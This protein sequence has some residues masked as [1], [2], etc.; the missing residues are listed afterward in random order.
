[1]GAGFPIRDAAVV[2]I[3]VEKDGSVTVLSGIAE[4]GQGG[5]N[6]VLQL[7]SEVLGLSMDSLRLSPLDTAYVPDSGAT[8]GSRGT[9]TSGNAAY[10]AAMNLKT[11]MSRIIARH[12]DV[13]QSKIT[14]A[15]NMLFVSGQDL[16]MRF[17]E[18]VSC[19]LKELPCLQGSGSWALPPVWWNFEKQC[20]ETYASFNFGA[21]GV[22]IEIDLISGAVELLN[23][24]SV[25]DIGRA[26]NVREIQGQIAGGAS[27]GYG[28]ALLEED[29]S[30]GEKNLT[31]NFDKYLLPTML[32]FPELEAIPLEAAPGCNPLGVKGVGEPASA[33]IAPAIINAI[34]DALQVRIRKLP[35][36]L[37]SVFAAI[38]ERDRIR[39]AVK[40]EAHA[41]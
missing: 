33:I 40:G 24:V 38:E 23:C 29:L 8:V 35:A 19:C 5:G 11:R 36:S 3:N 1:M 26:L 10:A 17:T 21:C 30:S 12:W 14:F 6:V 2:N 25:H 13:P 31:R 34:A 4:M 16:K 37:E 9:I 39:A 15:D 18:A 7:I 32:D 20:G 27:M 22:E 28:L 41:D